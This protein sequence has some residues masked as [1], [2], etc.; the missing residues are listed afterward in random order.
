MKVS[1]EEELATHF[2]LA[3]R[4]AR[5]NGCRLSVRTEGSAGQP[6]SSEITH[7]VCRS[8]SSMEK[9]TPATTVTGEVALGTAES[10]TLC[11]HGHLQAREPGDPE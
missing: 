5:G 10:E 4:P 2:G 7:S 8:C 6:S 11:M 3:R 9:A 1:Y